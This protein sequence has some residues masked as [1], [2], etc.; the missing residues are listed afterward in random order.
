M[1]KEKKNNFGVEKPGRH[2]HQ[3]VKVNITNNKTYRLLHTP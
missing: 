2:L 3:V 1:K